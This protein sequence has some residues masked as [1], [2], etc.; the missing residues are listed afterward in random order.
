M[1]QQSSLAAIAVTVPLTKACCFVP[2]QFRE[3]GRDGIR[4]QLIM[5]QDDLH[6]TNTPAWA[7]MRCL[8]EPAWRHLSL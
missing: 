7:E 3:I 5:D 1:L 6:W 4:C 8:S 2:D